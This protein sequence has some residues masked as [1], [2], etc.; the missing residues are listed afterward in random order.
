MS[1]GCHGA[2]SVFVG[3]RLFVLLCDLPEVQ[4]FAGKLFFNDT[5]CFDSRSQHILLSR[6]VVWLADSVHFIEVAK[7]GKTNGSAVRPLI[8]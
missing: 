8:H 5:S 4:L 2:V 1:S 7:D 3:V 6:E